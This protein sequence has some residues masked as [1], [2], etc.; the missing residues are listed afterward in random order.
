MNTERFI[1]QE[2]RQFV[3]LSYRKPLNYKV[4]KEDTIK[5]L[6][7]GYTEDVSQSGLLCNIA[8][9]VPVDSVL[10]LLLD[11]GALTICSEVEKRSVI[12]QH[13][14][15][16]R[17]VRT[18]HKKDGSFDVGVRF[19]TREEPDDK[20]MFQRVRIDNSMMQHNEDK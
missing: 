9:S 6:M 11:M 12:L 17:V 16:G 2:R 18:Y 5:K 7:T 15:L 3:R 20:D 14:I 19:L 13:G 1:G 4:C 10:W 8:E